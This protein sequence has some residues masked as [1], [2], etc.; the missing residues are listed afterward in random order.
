MRRAE[1]SARGGGDRFGVE[2]SRDEAP[3]QALSTATPLASVDAVLTL[4]QVEPESGP[5]E[6][7]LYR[8]HSLLDRLDDIRHDILAGAISGRK[9]ESLAVTLRSEREKVSDARLSAILDE[10]EL[11]AAVELAKLERA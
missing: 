2:S 1:R 3:A 4:Q 10:I 8:G 5:R 7:A 6:R 11:R 9:L